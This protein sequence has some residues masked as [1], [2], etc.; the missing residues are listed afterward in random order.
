MFKA[1]S[2]QNFFAVCY[3][4]ESHK[5]FVK[6]ERIS[7]GPVLQLKKLNFRSEFESKISDF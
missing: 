4:I 6:L 1:L 2:L 5:D 7:I 3:F